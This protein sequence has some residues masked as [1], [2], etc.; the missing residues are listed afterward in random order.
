MGLTVPGSLPTSWN[1]GE[2]FVEGWMEDG[3]G[4]S[5]GGGVMEGGG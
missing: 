5:E 4:G 1:C 3:E 2:H